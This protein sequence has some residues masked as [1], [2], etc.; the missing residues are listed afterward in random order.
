LV[1]GIS[2]GSSTYSV[3]VGSGAGTFTST[4]TGLSQGTK[5]FVRSFATNTQ[6]TGYGAETSFTT[7]TTPT[8]SVTATPSSL[9]TTSAVGGGTISSTG[10]ATITVSGLVWDANVN[11]SISLS[12]KT[13]DGAT[14][15]TFT[16]SITGL[17]Q[18]ATYHVR[19]YATNIIGTS[20][21]P[22]ITFTTLTTPTVSVTASVT[23]I[24]GTTATGGG[25]ISSDGGAS[26]TARGIVFGTATNSYTYTVTSGTGTGTYTSSLTGLSNGTTYYLRAYAS[27]S[28]GTVYG[29]SEVSFT[30]PSIATLASTTTSTITSSTAILG[31]VL[32]STGGATTAVGIQ[33]T[34]NADF[35]GSYSSTTINSNAVA[36]TYTTSISS[37]T[38]QTNYIARSFATN[39]AGTSY[40]PQVSFT[41]PVRPIAVGDSY[42]GGI[43]IY[44]AGPS[45]PGYDENTTHGLIAAKVD[46]GTMA[47]NNGSNPGTSNNYF[48]AGIG[49]TSI[50]I[51]QSGS[52]G[53]TNYAAKAC[54]DYTV[55]ETV[56]GIT[57]TYSDWYLGST[58]ENEKMLLNPAY[59]YL[60]G[61]LAGTYYW[62]SNQQTSTGPVPGFSYY[63]ANNSHIIPPA[64]A[65]GDALYVRK[66]DGYMN[67]WGKTNSSPVSV[68]AIRKF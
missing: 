27:N 14:S 32:S 62:A 60:T 35:T 24:T 18:G 16:S 39:S 59:L 51:A 53:G 7:Q 12:T 1:Y 61:G 8:V 67:Q 45:D 68:R 10:G 31:G 30:T 42:G 40:G 58:F 19:A 23:S 50:I 54:D 26:I 49:N 22:D 56:G 47:W 64:L 4:L 46:L 66:Y 38:P 9:T 48:G 41:T 20:Y 43:V 2:S 13:T 55:T 6:G 34:T 44:I 63:W 3:T 5:Y 15:G 37:L 65:V 57:T 52:N 29:P 25:T 36:G 21:G 17:T 11:P 28:A 33:Y